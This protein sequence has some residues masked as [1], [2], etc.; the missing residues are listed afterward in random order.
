M[1]RDDFIRLLRK[2]T[3]RLQT[4]ERV[5]MALDHPEVLGI[6]RRHAEALALR[7]QKRDARRQGG[8]AV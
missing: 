1:K 2:R 8:K 5:N 6:I 7:R 4:D 3:R